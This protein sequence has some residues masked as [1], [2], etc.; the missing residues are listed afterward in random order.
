MTTIYSQKK[1]TTT[2]QNKNE[3]NRWLGKNSSQQKF[4]RILKELHLHMGL[5]V[6]GSKY[7][8][9]ETYLPVLKKKLIHPLATDGPVS[10]CF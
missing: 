8:F 6:S 3:F 7:E 5:R 2:K 10:A 1:T 4:T 9:R